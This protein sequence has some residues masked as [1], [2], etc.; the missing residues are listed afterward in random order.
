MPN[1]PTAPVPIEDVGAHLLRTTGGNEKLVKSLTKSFLADAPKRLA[2]IR[3][4]LA[5]KNAAK[6]DT[7]AHALKGSI[8]IFG[9]QTAVT[10]AKNLEAMGRSRNL[11]GADAQFRALEVAIQQLRT[12]LLAIAPQD[13]KRTTSTTK[14]KPRT[15]RKRRKR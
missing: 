3:A 1:Q 13:K 11:D 6:L 7:T 12:E 10:A 14:T 2:A 4:A 8:A 15:S 9:A 5:A